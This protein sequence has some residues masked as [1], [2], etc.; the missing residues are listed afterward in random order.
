MSEQN[1][2]RPS[3]QFYPADWMSDLKLRRCTP[4]ARGVWVDVLCAFH[5][6]D[7]A[8]GMLRWTLKEIARTVGA[9]MSHV[10]ELADKAVL[11]GSDT[12]LDTALVYV[13]RSG[14]KAGPPVT[15]IAA[16]AGPIWYS[17]RL[18]IDDYVRTI[19]GEASRFGGQDDDSPSSTPAAAPTPAPTRAP[20]PATAHSPNPPFGDG[21]STSSSSPASQENPAT[22]DEV[23][24]ARPAAEAPPPAP[25]APSPDPAP[26]D[27]FDGD[28]A[29]PPPG[30]P[31]PGGPS[32]SP[33]KLPDCPHL[34]LLADWAEIL[35]DMPQHDPDLWG[36]TRADHLRARWRETAAKR[37]WASQQ[38]GRNYF[39]RLFTFCR[40]SPFLMGKTTPTMGRRP[41]QFEL[42]WL[43]NPTNWAR[44]HEGRY[45]EG[46]A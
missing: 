40:R 10:R 9:S 35:P 31:V 36:G 12:Y 46:D 43:V 39:R 28:D 7:D 37:K 27:L 5:D 6:S 17:K 4:A 21:S 29:A 34:A 11:R 3:F 18:V 19:R 42:E 44:V 1:K 33:G 20:K 23:A 8:Y 22:S 25:A 32:A 30:P 14:R 41:F 26:D 13:P 38:Q 16:Q 15:L 24:G 45:H 2:K